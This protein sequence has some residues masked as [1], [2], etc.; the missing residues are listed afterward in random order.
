M[1]PVGLIDKNKQMRNQNKGGRPPKTSAQKKGYRVNIKM[2][3]EEY[4]SLKARALNAGVNISEYVRQCI[5]NSIVKQRLTPEIQDYIRKLC[6]MANNLNQI[7]RKANAQGYIN[8]RSEYLHLA[9]K[10]DRLINQI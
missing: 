2:A 10:I 6:G 3:T 5:K 9:N 8:A 4:Y 7:A 1:H